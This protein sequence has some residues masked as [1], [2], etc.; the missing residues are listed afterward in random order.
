MDA[1]ASAGFSGKDK[2][3]WFDYVQGKAKP[4]LVVPSVAY[5]DLMDAQTVRTFAHTFHGRAFTVEAPSWR[6][7]PND[8]GG[9]V[10]EA[11]DSAFDADEACESTRVASE[12]ALSP[13]PAEPQSR[14]CEA[15][16]ASRDAIVEYAP[17]QRVPRGARLTGN[18]ARRRDPM[19]GTVE[20]DAEYAKF[21][22]DLE[23]GSAPVPS[24]ETLLNRGETAGRTKSS[25]AER[26]GVRPARASAL[27]EFLAATSS[28]WR[29]KRGKGAKPSSRRDPS[30]ARDAKKRASRDAKSDAK[31]ASRASPATARANEKKG[32]AGAPGASAA[33]R[34]G[35]REGLDASDRRR[36]TT[37]VGAVPPKV[38]ARPMREPKKTAV[39]AEKKSE[40]PARGRFARFGSEPASR[41]KKGKGGAPPPA[42]EE[43]REKSKPNRPGPGPG[44]KGE[45]RAPA[46]PLP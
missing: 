45:K 25:N 8:D 2:V 38:S 33:S 23:A 10:A 42:R 3:R 24:A 36:E 20:R 44:R 11:S 6:G 15:A 9:N 37:A 13:A 31:R 40:H 26:T 17:N 34:R 14:T 41:G 18:T 1:V 22:A 12:S 7:D 39:V 30:N 46:R 19:E 4:K 29:V 16:R 5:I 35:A 27:L 43:A 28:A 21:L 32:V